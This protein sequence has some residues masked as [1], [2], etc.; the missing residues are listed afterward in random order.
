VICTLD[1]GQASQYN[2]ILSSG[3]RLYKNYDP[4]TAR[5]QLKKTN[6]EPQ[7]AWRQDELIGDPAGNDVSTK[8]GETALLGAVTK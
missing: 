1:K 5:V 8:A 6:R 3:S 7:E 4:T 2:P